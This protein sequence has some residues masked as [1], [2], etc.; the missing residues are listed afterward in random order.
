LKTVGALAVGNAYLPI[1]HHLS[2]IFRIRKV[3][4]S[5]EIEVP[6]FQTNRFLNERIR[7]S[8][9]AVET[10]ELRIR[11]KVGQ[12]LSQPRDRF[13]PQFLRIGKT[14][15]SCFTNLSS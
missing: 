13:L 4:L 5:A 10:L 15:D 12:R 3:D 2:F 9:T 7:M 11:E 8:R 6:I 1:E 14:V